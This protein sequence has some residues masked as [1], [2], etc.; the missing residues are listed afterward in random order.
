MGGACHMMAARKRPCVLLKKERDLA[1]QVIVSLGRPS[2][3]LF[4]CHLNNFNRRPFLPFWPEWT[5]RLI[6]SDVSSGCRM[7]F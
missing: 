7:A 4:G 2:N 3:I 6:S 1:E 5:S